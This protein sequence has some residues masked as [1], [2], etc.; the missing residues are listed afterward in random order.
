MVRLLGFN[1]RMTHWWHWESVWIYE[2]MTR[3]SV[4]GSIKR[5]LESINGWHNGGTEEMLESV[6]VGHSGG[7][8][9]ESMKGWHLVALVE[10]W[11]P[12][13]E[14][15]LGA[16]KEC[17][18]QEIKKWDLIF[19]VVI[20]WCHYMRQKESALKKSFFKRPAFQKWP[21][22]YKGKFVKIERKFLV[23]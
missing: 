17:W 8:V 14:D 2:R 22:I 13:K 23:F 16:S 20:F 19:E 3:C 9:F 21:W 4:S 11:V 12:W 6:K 1:E 10:R 18:S 5:V 15:A 7:V